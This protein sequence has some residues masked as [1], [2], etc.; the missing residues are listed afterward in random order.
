MLVEGVVPFVVPLMV[1]GLV[2]GIV[3]VDVDE[4]AGVSVEGSEDAESDAVRSRRGGSGGDRTE[5]KGGAVD[6]NIT[7][8]VII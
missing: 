7:T 3:D 6:M 8:C 5:S 2:G 4:G 1:D